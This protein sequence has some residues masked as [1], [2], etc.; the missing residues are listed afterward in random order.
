M[1]QGSG[2]LVDQCQGN[3]INTAAAGHQLLID[4]QLHSPFFQ[5]AEELSSLSDLRA[6]KIKDTRYL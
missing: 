1:H 3:I 4:F 2:V 6:S 5:F